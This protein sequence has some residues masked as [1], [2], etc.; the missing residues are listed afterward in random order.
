M[1]CN[2][3]F[4][5]QISLVRSVH[6]LLATFAIPAQR[7]FAQSKISPATFAIPAQRVFAQSKISPAVAELPLFWSKSKSIRVHR[8]VFWF[9]LNVP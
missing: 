7:V 2:S 4:F 6:D 8:V 9:P 1:F 3:S 5:A